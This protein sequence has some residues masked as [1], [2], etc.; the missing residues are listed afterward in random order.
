MFLAIK[1]KREEMKQI[2]E[3]VIEAIRDDERHSFIEMFEAAEIFLNGE[4]CECNIQK[5][6]LYCRKCDEALVRMRKAYRSIK[7]YPDL[8]PED[9]IPMG[10][11]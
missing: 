5:D 1:K 4:M 9:D 8:L 2:R 3:K 11:I 6:E 10:W 7:V